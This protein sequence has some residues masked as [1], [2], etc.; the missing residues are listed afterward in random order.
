ME[1]AAARTA[2]NETGAG[3]D[4]LLDPALDAFGVGLA[5]HGAHLGAVRERVAGGDSLD[6]CL[7]GIGEVAVGLVLHEDALRRD[8]HLAGVGEARQGH[9]VR[10]LVDVSVIHDDDGGIGTQLHRHLLQ[11]RRAADVLA[12]ISRA[13]EGDL[14]NPWVRGDGV[15]DGGTGTGEDTDRFGWKA[16]L[17]QNLNELDR[18]QRRV[19]RRFDDDGVAGSQRRSHLVAHKIQ[20]EVERRDGDDDAAGYAQREAEL[21]STVRG[22]TQIEGLAGEPLGLFGRQG[23]RLRRAT[24]LAEALSQN[25]ALFQRDRTAQVLLAFVHQPRRPIEQLVA[26]VGRHLAHNLGAFRRGG[27][28]VRDVL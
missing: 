25:L 2:G 20:R 3:G 1:G 15:A 21:A 8:T 9:T 6:A 17:Q 13:G 11:A 18:R 5:D 24:R 7:Q 19:A 22:R 28:G 14:S 12:H 26:L 23:D 16:D 10:D 4:G 27:D